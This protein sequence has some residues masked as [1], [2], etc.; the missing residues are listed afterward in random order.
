MVHIDTSVYVFL[1]VI[2]RLVLTLYVGMWHNTG[3]E[4]RLT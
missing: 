1:L 2:D 3:R 4:G